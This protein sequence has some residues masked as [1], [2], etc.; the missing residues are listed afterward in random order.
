MLTRIAG[1]TY[2]L[3]AAV[4]IGVY[5]PEPGRCILIDTGID[6]QSAKTILKAVRGENWQVSQIINTH[7]HSDHCGGNARIVQ[8][9]GATV[10]ASALE[11]AIVTNP[12]LEPFYLYTAAPPKELQSKFLQ[13]KPSRVGQ[14]VEAEEVIDGLRIVALPGH[15]PGL[16]GVATPDGVLFTGDA[17]FPPATLE[18]YYVPYF[19]DVTTA[20]ATLGYLAGMDYAFYLP[21]HGTLETEIA[22]TLRANRERL[23]QISAELLDRLAEPQ[24]KEDLVAALAVAH[25]I[26]LNPTQYHLVSGSVSAHLSHLANQGRIIAT[27]AAGRL[28]WARKD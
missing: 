17:Y 18:K 2:Y 24:S 27:F 13:A 16:I 15:A 3:P 1:N 21:G 19:A 28:L 10:L 5:N 4:N 26:E 14:V 7:S 22:A 6:D 11:A 9:T 8:E 23:E 20:L 25:Q 12:Y